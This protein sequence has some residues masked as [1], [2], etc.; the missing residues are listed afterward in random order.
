MSDLIKLTKNEEQFRYLCV[1]SPRTQRQTSNTM[2]FNTQDR[3]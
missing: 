2:I 3:I 1:D